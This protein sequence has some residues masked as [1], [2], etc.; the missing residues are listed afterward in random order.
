MKT[1]V[2]VRHSNAEDGDYHIKDFD[3]KLTVKGIKKAETI[4][5]MCAGLYQAE[6]TLF[7]SSSAPRALQ[8]AEVFA[9]TLCFKKDKLFSSEFLY[10]GLS[11]EEL[12]TDL[13]QYNKY[14]TIWIFGHNPEITGLYNFF[15]RKE[16]VNFPKCM[17]A[18]LSFIIDSFDKITEH[19]GKS[20]FIV[21]PKSV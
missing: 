14:D 5:R 19:S 21:N 3:R 17:V 4:A 13:M 6:K 8:T 11:P 20:I 12:L 2:F 18:A 10:Y 9:K 15:S 1:I 7:Y 16:I